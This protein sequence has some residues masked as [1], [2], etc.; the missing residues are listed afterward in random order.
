MEIHRPRMQPNHTSR[1]L[2]KQK[3]SSQT[4]TRQGDGGNFGPDGRMILFKKLP[5]RLGKATRVL[6]L[7]STLSTTAGGIVNVNSFSVSGFLTALGTEFTN[8]A[9]EYQSFRVRS[10]KIHC[11]PVLVGNTSLAGA[12]ANQGV[13]V[14]APWHQFPLTARSS[15]MQAARKAIWSM[16]EETKFQVMMDMDNDK[17]WN[18]FGVAYPADRDYGV[19][20][21]SGSAATFVSSVVAICF[22]EAVVDFRGEQ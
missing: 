20:F 6:A 18:E 21:C 14:A 9:Q 5:A 12:S 3:S 8:F 16:A 19:T 7:D 22:Q 1:P 4:T 10:F 2:I 15:V 13:L 11:L 17:L